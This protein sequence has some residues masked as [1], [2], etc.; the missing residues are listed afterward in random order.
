MATINYT[1]RLENI[2]S[3]KFDRELNESVLSKTFSSREI[4]EN[5]KYLAESMRKI[6]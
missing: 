3:R 6:E 5:V 2:Q 4:P 1:K